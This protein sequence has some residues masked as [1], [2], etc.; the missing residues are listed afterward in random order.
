M[1]TSSQQFPAMVASIAEFEQ[2]VTAAIAQTTGHSSTALLVMSLQRFDRVQALL[3]SE[4]AEIARQKISACIV[5]SL[6]DKDRFCFIN[7]NEIWF[8]LPQLSSEALAVLA[9][10]RLLNALSAPI[11]IGPHALFF[12]PSVGIACAPM[13]ARNSQELLHCADLAL[14][15]TLASNLRF[16]M[17]PVESEQRDSPADLPKA[18][19]EVLNLNALTMCFQPKVDLRSNS[20]KS[21]E[22]LVRWPADHT[23]TVATNILIDVAEQFGLI[24]KLTFQVFNKVLQEITTWQSK[25][26]QVVVWVNLSARLLGLEQLPKM[27]SRALSIWNVPASSIGFE[28]TESAFINDIDRTTALLF[29][30]KNLGFRLSIDDFGTGYSSLSYLRRF[31]IDELKIDRVFVQ[32]MADSIQDKQIVQSIIGLAHN[33][34][35]SVVAEGVE[36][37]AALNTLKIMGCDEIQGYYFARPMPAEDLIIWC[38]NFHRRS[39]L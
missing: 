9:V 28:I 14:K 21:V 7:E 5:P 6:R 36:E 15:N 33:F 35:L 29:E 2:L 27:L 13:H 19:E 31:P 26:L 10:H 1:S 39:A 18:L 25:G 24:E 38:E 4:Y 16:A 20:I 34:G 12:N 23:Q 11:K 8:L 30:L 3:D 22:A 37:E 17:A 32:G